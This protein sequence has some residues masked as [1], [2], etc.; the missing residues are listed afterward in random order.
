MAYY[1][2]QP[3]YGQQPQSQASNLQFY[4]SSYSQQPV[5]GHSTPFQA[6]T[7]APHAN[8]YPNA[9]FGG[10]AQ[11]PGVSGRMGESHG[12]RTGLLAAFGTEGYDGEP[13]L[14]EE[15]GVNFEHIKS[16]VGEFFLQE[17][18]RADDAG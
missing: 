12:L 8:S 15:L 4:P 5:S 16:K 13:P 9:Q 7:G 6:Y 10:F 11:Q 14:L 18:P 1:S 3:A 2:Q 17:K